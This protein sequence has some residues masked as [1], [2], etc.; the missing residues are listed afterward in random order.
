MV[1]ALSARIDTLESA[2][3]ETKK[4]RV[5]SAY[6]L[7]IKQEYELLKNSDEY[8]SFNGK[9]KFAAISKACSLK[10]KVM[11]PK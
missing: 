4:K 5:P 10:W 6:A 1:S 11:H 2:K 9:E 7:F 8:S 3:P